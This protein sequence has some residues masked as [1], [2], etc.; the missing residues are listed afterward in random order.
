MRSS[1]SPRDS[2]LWILNDHNGQMTIGELRR[3]M[4]LR[5]HE[6]TPI[7]VDLERE[8]KIRIDGKTISIL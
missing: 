6:L 5:L 7:L 3:R 1:Q 2:I 4:G 8:G